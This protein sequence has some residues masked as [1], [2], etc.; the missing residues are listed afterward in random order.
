MS[1]ILESNAPPP[2]PSESSD[3][4][5]RNQVPPSRT[6]L[7]T[8]LK[9]SQRDW[10]IDFA[11]SQWGALHGSLDT[12]R[13]K[14][15]IWEAR[16]NNDYNDRVG[17]VDVEVTDAIRSIFEHQNY[18]L[19]LI[20]GF[21]D[22]AY[23]QARDDI[24]GSAP[25]FTATPEGVD[26]E[27]LSER[28]TK[29]SDWK[30]QQTNMVDSFKESLRLASDVGTGFL[31]STW[32]RE[33]E[34]YEKS[35]TVAVLKD[36]NPLKTASGD[37]VF[38][39]DEITETSEPALAQTAEDGA[40][41]AIGKAAANAVL[42][43]KVRTVPAKD[44]STTIPADI[45]WQEMAIPETTVTYDNILSS[46][47]SYKDIAFDQTAAHLDLLHTDIFHRRDDLGILDVKAIYKLSD[48]Q[49]SALQTIVGES[50]VTDSDREPKH[51]L[52][53]SSPDGTVYDNELEANPRI[54]I[55]EGYMRCDP[56][57]TGNPIRIFIV[58]SPVLHTI[59]HVDYLANRTPGGIVPIFPV[60][61]FRVPGRI[62]GVGYLEKY[63]REGD[64]VDAEFNAVTY[65]DRLASNPIGAYHEGAL[66]EDD[67][68]DSGVELRPGRM[69]KLA[70]GKTLEDFIQFLRIPDSNGR[71]VEVMQMMMQMLQMRTGIT[72][73]AQGELKGV[74]QSNTA[75]GVNQITSRGAV[76]LKTPIAD[77]S[78]DI[79]VALEYNVHLLYAN[80]NK[81]ETF[82]WGEGKDAE[83]L[84][85]N[86]NDVR[87]LRMNIRIILSQSQAQEKHN[88]SLAA[89]SIMQAYIATP[90]PEK[91][92]I[93]PMVIQGIKAL[94]FQN[95]D[96]IVREAVT[97]PASLAE[98]LPEELQ[99]PYLQFLATLAAHPADTPISPA[100][101][102]P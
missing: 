22:F 24:L 28:V 85:L 102:T 69:F 77:A 79:S 18:S 12:W 62:Y 56:L 86:P 71:T 14:C 65:R 75:T 67:E 21:A 97:D 9:G 43:G 61:M 54:D 2:S 15:Q 44:P 16:S 90:E 37:F 64:F 23:A 8:K 17:K 31:K 68:E 32:R 78:D 88:N 96:Q 73:A 38:N 93:R 25:F 53:E 63:H 5:K 60:R 48:E 59:L 81:E 39:T 4:R 66:D 89:M 72:S 41:A 35:A 100:E 49:F 58:F 57:Q 45:T 74:P 91:P 101:V 80:H 27:K 76:L 20:T 52:D 92:G 50:D 26:D 84:Q 7:D 6:P 33:V 82:T 42:P 1:I 34:H 95:A 46:C 87:G 83:L 3:G 99:Q 36:G 55:V 29:H 47:V 30:F 19:G 13:A 70:E 94:G 40:L 51:H 10:L 98:L 11:I